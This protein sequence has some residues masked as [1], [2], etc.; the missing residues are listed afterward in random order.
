M[1]VITPRSKIAHAFDFLITLLAWAGFIYLIAGGVVA[2]LEGGLT[3]PAVPFWSKLLPTVN[4]LLIYLIAALFNGSLLVLW[5]QYN[6][7]RYGGQDR[8]K[9]VG[10]LVDEARLIGFCTTPDLLA[11]LRRA[12]S[13]VV[14]HDVGGRLIEVE[15]APPRLVSVAASDH[16]SVA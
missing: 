13:S 6:R 10:P 12:R 2:V 14:H 3:G 15:A 16:A 9:F 11:T 8:R 1:I 5:A 4:T 7:A